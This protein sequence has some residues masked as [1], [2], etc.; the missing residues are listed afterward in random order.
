MQL[1]VVLNRY[2]SLGFTNKPL[3]QLFGLS[4]SLF[5][6]NLG[7]GSLFS[8]GEGLNPLVLS[9]APFPLPQFHPTFVISHNVCELNPIP[10]RRPGAILT[11]SRS[12]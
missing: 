8:G 12:D 4:R 10:E 9:K 3:A 6:G 2:L 7:I 1:N 5:G 11:P